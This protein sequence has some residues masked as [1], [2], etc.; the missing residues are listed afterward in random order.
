MKFVT[1]SRFGSM[2][3]VRQSC[4]ERFRFSRVVLGKGRQHCLFLHNALEAPLVEYEIITVPLDDGTYKFKIQG[5]D[6]LQ[7][8]NTGIEKTATLSERLWYPRNFAISNIVDNITPGLVGTP[9][10]DDLEVWDDLDVWMDAFTSDVTFTW[11]LP[12]GGTTPEHFI[13]YGNGGSGN[14]IDRMTPLATVNGDVLTATITVLGGSWL[15]VVESE[16]AGVESIN[17]YTVDAYL[18]TEGSLDDD[19]QVIP[20]DDTKPPQVNE[21]YL[22][23]NVQLRNVSVGRCEIRFL[24]IHGSRASH[25]RVYH[26]SGTGTI[27]WS[28]Y[29]YRFER[30]NTIQQVYTTAQLCFTDGATSFKFGIRAES[31]SGIV[32]TNTIE[33]E[34]KLDGIA[35]DEVSA[36]A[37]SI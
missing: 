14:V 15:F 25:F 19:F 27:N 23:S 9:T 7:N 17:W 4:D 37:E 33:N 1:R 32:D 3:P 6:T 10:W 21:D 30:Q 22:P 35:P 34:V 24:W 36:T 20:D 2:N 12:A 11:E 5:M 18:K 16:A 8:I 29:A 31:S 28:S 26:D 13:I